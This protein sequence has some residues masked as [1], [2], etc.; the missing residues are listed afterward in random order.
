MPRRRRRGNPLLARIII[1]SVVVH[2]IALPILAHFGAFKKI[3]QQFMHNEV[4]IMPPPPREKQPEIKKQAKQAQKTAP[5]GKNTAAKRSAVAKSN[6]NQPKV[7]AART[8]PGVGGDSGP[9]VD[10]NGSGK[11]G[12]LPTLIG[13]NKNG[14][15]AP[16]PSTPPASAPVTRPDSRVE[17][18]AE[19]KPEPA[20]KVHVPVITEVMPTF[21]PNPV[22]PDDLRSEA[23]DATVTAQFMVQADGAARDVR[24]VKSSGNDTLDRLALDTAR[25]WR[26][27]PATR[28]GAPIESRVILHIEFEVQ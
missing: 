28:D 6:L 17:P 19:A 18:K 20:P 15:S 12:A 3:Q 9:T 10:P 11:A 2:I 5:R 21:N 26:F 7:V 14:G 13:G 22:I 23:L 24:I 4:V 8:A 16:P 27:K 1:I 25:K